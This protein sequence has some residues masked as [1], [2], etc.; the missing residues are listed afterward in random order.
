MFTRPRAI[1]AL[2]L[3]VVACGSAAAGVDLA[4]GR[5]RPPVLVEG[6]VIGADG[7]PVAATLMLNLL[8]PDPQSSAAPLLAMG[9]ADRRGRFRLQLEPSD[10][11]AGIAAANAGYLNLRLLAVTGEAKGLA[12][13]SRRWD[14]RRWR[15]N[16]GPA[17]LRVMAEEPLTDAQRLQL[18][19]FRRAGSAAQWRA[20]AGRPSIEPRP[21]GAVGVV[22]AGSDNPYC[23]RVNDQFLTRYTVIGELHTWRDM[24][25][26]FSY[27]T[28][29]DSD[30]ST[31]Y[32][33][34]GGTT[35]ALGGQLHI[36]TSTSTVSTKTAAADYY[37]RAIRSQFEYVKYHFAGTFCYDDATYQSPWKWT[38]G[39]IIDGT[40]QTQYD[41]RCGTTYPR[42][43]VY[44]RN[45]TFARSTRDFV[46]WSGAASVFGLA[47]K[48]QTGASSTAS[49]TYTFG[50]ETA[51]H[52]ICGS[53][54]YPSTAERV[55]AGP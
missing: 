2:S 4:V 15:A 39:G 6:V 42:V 41:G 30:I 36:G 45:T 17:Q 11:L 48:A 33:W 31:G 20:E 37:G 27:G 10:A 21:H 40:S 23:Y 52:R 24:S 5:A 49:L 50:P 47:L 13:L 9:T 8:D 22:P 43:Y 29:A 28:S 25:A 18:D 44:D 12:M 38:G 34:D 35:W 54:D 26:T 1:F 53:N 16:V 7:D 19:R 51:F 46:N 55:F 3:A 32:S 14:G